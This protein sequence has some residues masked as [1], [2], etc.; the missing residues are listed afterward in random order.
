MSTNQFI[1]KYGKLVER[2]PIPVDS[3]MKF[4]SEEAKKQRFDFNDW[5]R[6]V[7]YSRI[8]EVVDACGLEDPKDA[9]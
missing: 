2:L 9:A 7:L 5:A 8:Q 1:R 4:I 6:D 3:R